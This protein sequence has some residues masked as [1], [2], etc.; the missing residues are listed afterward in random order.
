M[1]NKAITYFSYQAGDVFQLHAE[2][3]KCSIK[4]EQT[5]EEVAEKMRQSLVFNMKRGYYWPVFMDTM[6]PFLKR[7]YD[8]PSILPLKDM[9]FDRKKLV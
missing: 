9:I 3:K 4:K 6:V 5:K 1:S 7:D 8:I 2:A